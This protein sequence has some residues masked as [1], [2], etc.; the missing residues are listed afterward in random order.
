MVRGGPQRPIAIFSLS[1]SSKVCPELGA[2][3]F[4]ASRRQAPTRGLDVNAAEFSKTVPLGGVKKPPTRAR[5]LQLLGTPSYPIAP[6]DAPV[7][8]LQGLSCTA[9]FETAAE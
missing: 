1:L 4:E 7:V 2:D 9:S 8:E 6:R 3:G 5:G